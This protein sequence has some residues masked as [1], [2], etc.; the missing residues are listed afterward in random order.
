MRKIKMGLICRL[1]GSRVRGF[2][3]LSLSVCFGM[4]VSSLAH[5]FAAVPGLASITLLPLNPKP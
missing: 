2:K 3:L 1:M 5:R 4:Q